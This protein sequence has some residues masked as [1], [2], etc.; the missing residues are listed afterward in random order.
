[1]PERR[2]N[3][4]SEPSRAACILHVQLG[5]ELRTGDV[6]SVERGC[7]PTGLPVPRLEKRTESN[8]IDRYNTPPVLYLQQ[9]KHVLVESEDV[10]I[11]WDPEDEE[12]P[13]NGD[14]EELPGRLR[15]PVL[16]LRGTVVF[17]SVAAPIAAGRDKTVAAIDSAM[18][19]DR[20]L[21]AVAQKGRRD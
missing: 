18:D 16:P 4:P 13:E 21:F 5:P 19:G 3:R 10:E 11:A 1:M 17:P 15:L 2:E 7:E 14:G 8:M 20:L 12:H 9:G 6:P